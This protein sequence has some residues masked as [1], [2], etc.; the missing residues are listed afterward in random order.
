MLSTYILDRTIREMY[1]NKLSSTGEI[2]FFLFVTFSP[3]LCV[4]HDKL[5][6]AFGS[7]PQIQVL[8]WPFPAPEILCETLS[9]I[10][11]SFDLST[12]SWVELLKKRT[13]KAIGFLYLNCRG[14][15]GENNLYNKSITNRW[16]YNSNMLPFIIWY[17]IKID[18]FW[19]CTI[20][21]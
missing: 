15:L 2:T 10:R 12:W 21:H 17:T 7:L 9:S 3:L 14:H 18:T 5:L 8:H 13:F 1:T 4:L 20:Y 11:Q 16:V 6:Q 19:K